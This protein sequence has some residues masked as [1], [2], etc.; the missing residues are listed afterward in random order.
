M[1]TQNVESQIARLR[2]EIERLSAKHAEKMKQ[3]SNSAN[4]KLRAAETKRAEMLAQRI[5]RLNEM[6]EALQRDR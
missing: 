4:A 6:L 2:E 5:R 3:Q 1:F